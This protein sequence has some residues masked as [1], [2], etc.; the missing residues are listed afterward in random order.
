MRSVLS[1]WESL[2]GGMNKFWEWMRDSFATLWMY[3]MLLNFILKMAKMID[4]MCVYICIHG[5][6]EWRSRR[7]SSHSYSSLSCL[8]SVAVV[9]WCLSSAVLFS[10][11]WIQS[12]IPWIPGSLIILPHEREDFLCLFQCVSQNF[13]VLWQGCA[14]LLLEQLERLTDV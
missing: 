8:H 9:L 13:F 14:R 5:L 3:L 11:I 7:Q 10:D 4:F 12:L 1:G 6:S 2:F